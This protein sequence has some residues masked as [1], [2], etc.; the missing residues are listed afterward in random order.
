MKRHAA[1]E[2]KRGAKTGATHA[3]KDSAKHARRAPE[4]KK[5]SKAAPLPTG[6]VLHD[7]PP[8]E[9]PRPP[10][11]RRGRSDDGTAF[12]PDPEDGPARI[13][14]SLAETL[15]EEYLESATRG[16]DAVEDTLEEVVPEELGGPFVETS[17]ADEFAD[18][19]DAANPEDAEAE[20]LPRPVAGLVQ[21]PPEHDEG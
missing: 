7:H 19:V 6:A 15:A 12:M 11:T 10:A 5:A 16:E 14:D 21:A 17:A 4:G 20:P 18:G 13:D 2:A 9:P 8:T 3:A 1:A